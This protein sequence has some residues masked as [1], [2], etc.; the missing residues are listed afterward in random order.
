VLAA[1]PMHDGKLDVPNDW[2]PAYPG[3]FPVQADEMR[4]WWLFNSALHCHE[5]KYKR[6]VSSLTATHAKWAVMVTALKGDES[7]S[8]AFLG[9]AP[10]K[11]EVRRRNPCHKGDCDIPI[12]VNVSVCTTVDISERAAII[13]TLMRRFPIL[14][15]HEALVDGSLPET[16]I[17]DR[18]NGVAQ[19][20]VWLVGDEG[21]VSSWKRFLT[22]H[23]L[24]KSTEKLESTHSGR[25]YSL[26]P[27]GTRWVL[28]VTGSMN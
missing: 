2:D 4:E 22:E 3:L 27:R 12:T 24:V 15:D 18:S 6:D 19:L 1:V 28:Q 8:D 25:R 21:T 23:S 26:E 11:L 10:H 13:K 14:K 20:D 9:E 7:A 17:Y 16:A 5:A